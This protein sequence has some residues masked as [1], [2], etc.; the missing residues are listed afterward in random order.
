MQDYLISE[1][2]GKKVI[3]LYSEPDYFKPIRFTKLAILPETDKT[4]I[5]ADWKEEDNGI[6]TIWN[7]IFEIKIPIIEIEEKLKH[8]RGCEWKYG[9][10]VD[11]KGNRFPA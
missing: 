9:Q 10:W 11:K 2:N 8:R 3:I 4:F 6:V 5:T 1:Y 7:Q